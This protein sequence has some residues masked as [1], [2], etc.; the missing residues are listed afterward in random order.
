MVV[1]ST[2]KLLLYYPLF[3]MIGHSHP[4][5]QLACHS[6]GKIITVTVGSHSTAFRLATERLVG[7]KAAIAAMRCL[8]DRVKALIAPHQTERAADLFLQDDVEPYASIDWAIAS[9]MANGL[10]EPNDP[11]CDDTFLPLGLFDCPPD[12]SDSHGGET[13]ARDGS[14]SPFGLDGHF[15]RCE[16]TPHASGLDDSARVGAPQSIWTGMDQIARL[17]L[18][19]RLA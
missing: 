1:E 9:D 6:I 10:L 7:R 16:G 14:A 17:P 5:N 3:P 4:M 13:S 15:G 2:V 12:A 11:P 8:H 19:G 18:T